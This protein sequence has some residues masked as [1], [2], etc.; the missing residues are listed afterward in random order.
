MPDVPTL[1]ERGIDVVHRMMRGLALP[2]GAPAESLRYWEA[3]LANVTGS[4]GWRTQYL[5]RFALT[6]YFKTG[7]R[8]VPSSRGTRRSTGMR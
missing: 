6:P 4:D 7:T 1:K 8:R 2:G 5:E 3:A